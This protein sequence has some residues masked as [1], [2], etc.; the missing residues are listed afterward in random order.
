MSKAE[1]L[2]CTRE[3][4]ADGTPFA[5]LGRMSFGYTEDPSTCGELWD[6]ICNPR[7]VVGE[8]GCETLA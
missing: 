5:K 1:T 4:K 8:H 3:E 7:I 6:N 2:L